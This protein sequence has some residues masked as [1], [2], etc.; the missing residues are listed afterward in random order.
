M[1][2]VLHRAVHADVIL[3]MTV[4]HSVIVQMTI[5]TVTFLL[6]VRELA[7]V[8]ITVPYGNL[9]ISVD[10]AQINIFL[11]IMSSKR[12]AKEN[13]FCFCT[14]ILYDNLGKENYVPAFR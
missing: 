7:L 8:T 13:V 4:L 9:K 2:D 11:E 5:D 14:I 6:A 12:I 10:N 1:V 3:P